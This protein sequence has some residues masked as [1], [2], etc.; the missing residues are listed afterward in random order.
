MKNKKWTTLLLTLCIIAILSLSV[1]ATEVSTDAVSG[2]WTYT[3]SYGEATIT[4]YSGNSTSVTVPSSVSGYTVVGIGSS[5]FNDRYEIKSITLPDT[6]QTI[7]SCAFQNCRSLTS[8]TLPK[9]LTSIGYRA[10]HNCYGLQKITIHSAK[11]SSCSSSGTFTNAGKNAANGIEVVFSDSVTVIPQYIFY[12]GSSDEYVRISSVAIGKNVN[13]INAWTFSGCYDLKTV[14]LSADTPIST[15][16]SNAFSDCS[17]LESITLPKAVTTLGYRAFH[18]C[19]SLQKITI[20]SAKLSSCSSSGTFTNAGKN[21]ANGI[22]V[23]F[24]DSVTVIPQYLFHRG[25][26]DEY[27]RVSSVEIGKNV[28][29]INAWAFCGCYDLKTV[30]INKYMKLNTIG[31]N[32]FNGCTSLTSMIIPSW[33]TD[34]GYCAFENCS[35]MFRLDVVNPTCK[36]YSNKNT[37]GVPGKTVVYGYAGTTAETY[38]NKYGYTFQAIHIPFSDVRV[39]DFYLNPT[40]WAVENGITNGATATTFN[41][42]GQCLRSQVITFLYR[43]VGSPPIFHF[44]GIPLNPFTDVKKTDF[45]YN[46]VI[47]AVQRG[48]TS[49]VSDTKFGSYDVC[50]RAAVVTF[51]WRAAGSPDPVS[52]RTPFTDVK[53]TDFFYKPVLWAVENGITAGLT[54]TTFGPTAECNRAQVVTFLYRAYN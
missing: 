16:D 18:N 30:D 33:V 25:S 53:S 49:G 5:V 15:I 41:P 39:P 31:D 19:Y 46:P 12:R 27:V 8:I 34:I 20:H 38:A 29:S 26:S 54:A 1:S 32:A 11:L 21:A 2:D 43:A 40:M 50:N 13:S 17:S 36:L 24:S 37:L 7:G 52:T 23:V 47:W 35:S 42:N 45:F 28:N 4:G 51:L 48:I 22:K 14:S 6:L 10:F 44:P 3:L 9:S